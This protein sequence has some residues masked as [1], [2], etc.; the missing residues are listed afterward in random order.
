[1]A[2][3]YQEKNS[4]NYR[5]G[6][7]YYQCAGCTDV[8][9]VSTDN[10]PEWEDMALGLEFLATPFRWSLW[11]R[12]KAAWRIFRYGESMTHDIWLTKK[13]ALALSKYI[14]NE[15]GAI[16]EVAK[17]TSAAWPSFET[18]IEMPE[19]YA[20]TERI[21]QLIDELIKSCLHAAGVMKDE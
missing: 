4:E 9:R 14:Y 1:M 7:S 6:K 15:L 8:L 3:Y 17:R 12:L 11:Y 10:D 13:Q 5:R 21:K 18:P 19:K 16:K 20:D 2:R